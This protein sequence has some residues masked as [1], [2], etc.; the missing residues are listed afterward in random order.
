LLCFL[1]AI[2]LLQKQDILPETPTSLP[3]A[4]LTL[5]GQR[6]GT[7][8]RYRY[9]EET[10]ELTDAITKS[11]SIFIWGKTDD[12][13]FLTSQISFEG[14][15]LQCRLQENR[16]N[17]LDFS[18]ARL[19]DKPL[20]NFFL[21][22]YKLTYRPKGKKAQ[23][24]ET[25]GSVKMTGLGTFI[26][27]PLFRL[28]PEQIIHMLT[29]PLLRLEGNEEPAKD[30]RLIADDK[31]AILWFVETKVPGGKEVIDSFRTQIPHIEEKESETTKELPTTGSQIT[32]RIPVYKVGEAFTVGYWAYRVFD[33]AW[34]KTVDTGIG[35]TRQANA[36]YL[37]IRLVC[38]NA[39]SSPSIIPPFKLVD[40]EGRQYEQSYVALGRNY[41]GVLESLNPTVPRQGIILFDVPQKAYWLEL[42][43]GFL[44]LE[45]ARVRIESQVPRTVNP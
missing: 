32:N 26:E 37:R 2:F 31:R 5:E 9:S 23:D 15:H 7:I 14:F 22:K 39:D 35:V 16:F 4:F 1:F 6:G 10:D 40:D 17:K 20:A 18:V 41:I 36:K 3:L 25:L 38:I 42:D 33:Y 13:T 19:T 21:A 11:L 44:S 30:Y 29:S 34:T 28:S 24:L 27:V 12:H 45:K 8:P 43:G